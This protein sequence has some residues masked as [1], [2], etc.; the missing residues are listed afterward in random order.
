M[1]QEKGFRRLKV[2][3]EAHTLTL[4]V[5]RL[6]NNFPKSEVFGLTSQLKRA[7]VSIPSNIVEGH[8]KTSLKEFL[9]HLDFANGSLVEVEYYFSLALDLNFISQTEYEEF[10]N[11][12]II[13]GN[14]LNG[15][16]KSLK[17]KKN[18]F[19]THEA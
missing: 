15:L 17:I 4:L 13:V 3:E 6:T 12:R 16:I 18:S 5:Y 19:M 7:M 11:Q 1:S 8:V 10:E 9:H 14:L 2:W